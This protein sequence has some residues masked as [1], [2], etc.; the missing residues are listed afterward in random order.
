MRLLRAL[1][2]WVFAATTIA[3]KDITDLFRVNLTSNENGGCKWVGESKLQLVLFD[4]H[5]LAVS[6]IR[7]MDDYLKDDQEEAKR[8][9]KAF[10]KGATNDDAKK[11]KSKACATCRPHSQRWIEKYEIVKKWIFNGGPVMGGANK[12]KPFLFCGNSMF[13]EQTLHSVALDGKGEA[14]K[15]RHGGSMFLY[16]IADY[17][18]RHE[19]AKK[20]YGVEDDQVKPV[21]TSINPLLEDLI[22]H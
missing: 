11:L 14:M 18:K 3:P 19:D 5:T 15:W 20:L 8:L 10:F 1:L 2:H 22:N 12:A 17:R 6:G 21:T 16:D 13:K 7:L 4:A 9:V